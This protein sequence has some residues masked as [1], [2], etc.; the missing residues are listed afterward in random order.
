MVSEWQRRDWNFSSQTLMPCSST[1]LQEFHKTSIVKFQWTFPA[2]YP[3]LVVIQP[4]FSQIGF[5]MYE[6]TACYTG[7]V[8]LLWLFPSFLYCLKQKFSQLS[9]S[10]QV[11]FQDVHT[12]KL[13]LVQWIRKNLFY[14]LSLSLLK[15]QLYYNSMLTP[16]LRCKATEV[17]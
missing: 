1:A 3:N 15:A 2:T 11:F 9:P 6:P 12:S 17:R 16:W 8:A 13:P 4:S 5:S 10:K 14:I 7:Y